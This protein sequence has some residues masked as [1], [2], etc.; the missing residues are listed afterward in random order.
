[1]IMQRVHSFLLTN[2]ENESYL[3]WDSTG[4]TDHR[5]REREAKIKALEEHLGVLPDGSATPLTSRQTLIFGTAIGKLEHKIR[6]ARL[7]AKEIAEVIG[8]VKPWEV[9]DKDTRLIRYFILECLSPCK[10]YV[11]QSTNLSYDDFQGTKSSWPVYICSWI[12]ITGTLCFFVYW[13][14]AWG[15]YEGG[16]TLAAWGAVYGTGAAQDILLVSV[17]KIIIVNYLPAQAMQAQLVRIRRVLADVSLKYIHC[18]E[19]QGANQVQLNES[20]TDIISMVQH[21]SAACRAARLD[22]V[23]AL[24]AAWL[25]RQVRKKADIPWKNMVSVS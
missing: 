10:R 14:F 13:I 5:F 21:M 18:R 16:D 23:K 1:M 12:M 25:L 9:D 4:A 15:L 6:K 8:C 2:N 17:T 3:P 11:L 22:E 24:P 7:Q 20:D 19:N